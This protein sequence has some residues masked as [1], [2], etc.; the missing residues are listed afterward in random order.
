MNFVV[1]N[2]RSLLNDLQSN[3][4]SRQDSKVD[5]MNLVDNL[6]DEFIHNI[7]DINDDMLFKMQLQEEISRTRIRMRKLDDL[8]RQMRENRSRMTELFL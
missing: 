1:C 6:S 3:S 4:F 2:N 5:F 8:T 7:D